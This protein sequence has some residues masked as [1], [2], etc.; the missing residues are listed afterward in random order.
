MKVMVIIPMPSYSSLL[1]R[2]EINS[3]EYVLLKNGVV[4][5]REGADEVNLLCEEN[6]AKKIVDFV[7]RVA[8]EHASAI[9]QLNL[10]PDA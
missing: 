7:T 10:P 2:C 8:P 3:P 6:Q 5:T 4:Q 1:G 9:R